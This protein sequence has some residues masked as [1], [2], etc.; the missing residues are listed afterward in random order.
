MKILTAPNRYIQGYGVIRDF[1][2]YMAHL[3]SRPFIIGGK[4]ALSTIKKVFPRVS[5]RIPWKK[6][7]L[8]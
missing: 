4:T 6:E 8:K 1:G 5:L 2:K 7:E 3:G